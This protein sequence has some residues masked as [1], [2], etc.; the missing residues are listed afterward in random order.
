MKK[1]VISIHQ[2]YKT[3]LAK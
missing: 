1:K 2:V 3:L